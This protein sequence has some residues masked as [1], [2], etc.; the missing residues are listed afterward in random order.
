MTTAQDVAQWMADRVQ[1]FYLPREATALEILEVFGEPFVVQTDAETWVIAPPVVKAF[2]KLTKETVVWVRGG[3]YW[4]TRE[5]GD[6]AR[7]RE[8]DW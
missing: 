8:V 7:A 2:D 1:E 6:P 3:Q 5:P 4:R